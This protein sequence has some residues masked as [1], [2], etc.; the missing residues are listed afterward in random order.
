MAQINDNEAKLARVYDSFTDTWF[1]LVG[2]I[3]PHTHDA[4]SL[5]PNTSVD[6]ELDR[7]SDVDADDPQDLD[8]LIYDSTAFSGSG[9]WITVQ[10]SDQIDEFELPQYLK[11]IDA[12]ATYL[13]QVNAS[14]IYLKKID[15][16][17]IYLTQI[18]ASNTYLTQNSA[19]TIYVKK[20]ET[21]TQTSID[22]TINLNDA[23]KF[24]EASIASP[25]ELLITIP[26][27]SSVDFPIGSRIDFAQTLDG[28]VRFVPSA[29]VSL[30]SRSN[31]R[32]MN[33]RWSQVSLF[34]R[35]ANAWLLYGDLTS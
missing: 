9:G 29:G 26:A 25:T 16:S 10:L 2:K 14:Q 21:P 12:S 15:A 13:S 22:Y 1:P 34:K 8:I 19:S 4:F 35:A 11:I 30:N 3:P 33:L 18:S 28:P 7:L 17:A 27:D 32:R 5:D 6:V 20:Y 31:N 23:N 24:V